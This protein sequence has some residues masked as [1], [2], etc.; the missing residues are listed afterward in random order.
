MS[1]RMPNL[2]KTPPIFSGDYSHDMWDEIN[3]AKT[4]RQLRWALYTV[5]CRLQELETRLERGIYGK[6][7]E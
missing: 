7:S 4:V 6:S 2:I 1:K 5:C 3:G